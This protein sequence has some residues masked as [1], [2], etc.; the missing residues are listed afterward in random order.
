MSD[1]GPVGEMEYKDLEYLA[2][3]TH[4]KRRTDYENELVLEVARVAQ[5][6]IFIWDQLTDRNLELGRELGACAMY[7]AQRDKAWK[8]LNKKVEPNG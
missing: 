8:Q 1:Y 2:G 3:K 6:A 4:D 7:K 5:E